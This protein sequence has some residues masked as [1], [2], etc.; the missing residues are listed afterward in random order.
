MLGLLGTPDEQDTVAAATVHRRGWTVVGMHELTGHTP[1]RYRE[2]YERVAGWLITD[3]GQDQV[4]AWCRR[5]PREQA[6]RLFTL[7][8]QGDRPP[9][10]VLM[11]EWS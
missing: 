1:S 9:E 11:L 4:A 2:A 8:D 5:V 6:P 7:I 3:L 10:P